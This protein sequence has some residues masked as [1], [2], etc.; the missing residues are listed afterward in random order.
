MRRTVRLVLALFVLAA[1]A[2]PAAFAAERMWIG[3]HDDPSFRWV[4]DRAARIRGSGQ[5]NSTIMRLLVQWNLVAKTRSGN[6]ADPFDLAYSFDD[7]DEA[8]RAAQEIDQEVILSISGTPSW[9][10][11][12]R[13]P[14]IMPRR[15]ADFTAFARA[16]A[17]RYSGRNMGYPFVRFWS[18]WNEPNLQRFLSPQFNGAGKSV[19]PANYAKLAAAGYAGIKAGS[20]RAQIAIGETSAR[21]T[22]R[23]TGLRPTHSPGR[24]AEL[25]AKANPRLKFDAWGH[26]PYPSVPSSPPSQIVRWPNVSLASLPRF[27]ESLKAWFKRRSVPIWVTEYGHQTKPPDALGV[28]YATQAAYI[29]QSISMASSLPFVTMFIWFV[30]QDTQGQGPEWESGVYTQGGAAKGTSVARFTASAR[31][32]DA[33][34]GVLRLRGGTVTPLVNLYTRRYCATDVPGTSIGMTWRVFRGGRLI[35]VG[36]QTAPLRA[37]CT[38]SARLRFNVV[39]GQTYTATFALNDIS[40]VELNRRLTIR[41]T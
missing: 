21:G 36:Q 31:P 26:H 23:P 29:Q 11:G 20:P 7:V 5:T 9:A 2:T 27:D 13:A 14:N 28:S 38:I 10:N 18:I 30:Y 15:V 32:L 40:G 33:R 8:V 19:A 22:D 4:G 3:F 35:A 12:G 39:K 6:A 41:G 16:I 1:V 37:D 24:F 25:V 34:N 17:S